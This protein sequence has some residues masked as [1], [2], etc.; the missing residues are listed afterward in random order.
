MMFV[1]A[2]L[3]GDQVLLDQRR[4]A[5]SAT[6]SDGTAAEG[7]WKIPVTVEAGDETTTVLMVPHGAVPLADVSSRVI[8]DPE[9][10]GFFRT[11]YEGPLAD[12]LA[13]D[14]M[15]LTAGQRYRLFDDLFDLVLAGEATVGDFVTL[16]RALDSETSPPVWSAV[17]SGFATLAHVAGDDAERARVGELFAEVAK[18]QLDALGFDVAGPDEDQLVNEVR[19]TLYSAL[20]SLSRDADVIAHARGIFDGSAPTDNASVESAAVRVIG[21]T[22]DRSDFDECFSRFQNAPSPQIERRYL[23]ALARFDDADAIADMCART[24][25]GSIRSQDAAFLLGQALGN[26]H[27][28]LQVWDFVTGNWAG[29][30]DTVPDNTVGRMLGG[31]QWLEHADQAGVSAFL[32][33]HEVPQARLAVAQHRERLGVHVALRG[34][35]SDDLAQVS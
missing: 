31:V 30:N 8:V 16:C 24:L 4:F 13:A 18:P 32:D 35:F 17:T 25:D 19:A 28:G 23:F 22:G 7:E 12:R 6:A 27:H 11:R 33:A 29:I 15:D 34:R 1:E 14:L 10:H 20:G 9:G 26:R 3:D 5:L 21:S 2:S